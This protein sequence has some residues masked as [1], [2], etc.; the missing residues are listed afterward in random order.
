MWDLVYQY[1]IDP[2]VHDTGYNPVNTLTWAIVLGLSLFGVLRLLKALEIRI[3]TRFIFSL[4]PYIFVGS[5]LRVIE[6]ANLINPPASYLLITPLIYFIVFLAVLTLLL[7]SI[8]ITPEFYALFGSFGMLWTLL[9]LA[10]LILKVD[11][12]NLWVLP[13]IILIALGVIIP[14]YLIL[15]V[16]NEIL[17]PSPENLAI[18]G[19]HLLDASSTFIGVDYLSYQGKHVVER[20]LIEHTG[21]ALSMIPLKLIILLPLLYLL[22]R[23]LKD[24]EDA[25][26]KGILI[27]T[28]IVIGLAPAIRNTTRMLFGI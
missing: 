26:L 6:D 3:D 7:I 17:L 28:L 2:I 10:I 22:D 12:L 25:D 23:E 5:T 15:R 19:S 9:N 4:I 27:L 18:L 14:L 24:E 1:Y 21:T 20:F 11:A 8:R 13:A 16:L